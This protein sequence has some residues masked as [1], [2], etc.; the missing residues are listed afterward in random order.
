MEHL[1]R[2]LEHEEDNKMTPY[3]L[4]VCLSP[5][6]LRAPESLGGRMAIFNDFGPA[7]KL[8]MVRFQL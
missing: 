6:L 3:N 1:E 5:S 4:A 2:V 8:V 7:V